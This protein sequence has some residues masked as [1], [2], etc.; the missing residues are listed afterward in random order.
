[1]EKVP[2]Y[3]DSNGCIGYCLDLRKGDIW[4]GDIF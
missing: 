4:K 1:M 3:C 2:R